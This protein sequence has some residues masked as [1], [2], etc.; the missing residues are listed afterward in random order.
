M[1]SVLA[2]FGLLADRAGAAS[3]LQPGDPVIAIDLD[4][5]LENSAYPGGETPANAVDQNSATK[6]LNQRGTETGLI[7]TPNFGSSTIQSFIITTAN[8]AADRDPTSYLLYGTNDAILSTDNS[9]GN[10]GEA[11]TQIAS[12]PVSLP[13][14]RFTPGTVA[15]FA[16]GLAF[17]SYKMLFPTLK[18]GSGSL[19]QIADLQFFTGAD[20]AGS[21][22]L[23]AGD[24]ALA[25]HDP[26][27]SQSSHPGGE[28]PPNSIDGNV[29]SKYLNFGE[30]NSG[31]IVT[32]TI[33]SSVVRSFQL[34]TANDAPARDPSSWAL[35]G[36]NDPITSTN[37]SFGNAEN[38][39]MIGS[40][41][42]AL[43]DDRFALGPQVQVPNET[44][45]TSYRFVFTG[46]KDAAAA[47]S[48]QIA[49]IQFFDVIPEP[50][51]AAL[52]ALAGILGLSASRRRRA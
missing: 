40:G 48:M 51:S 33:G 5:E 50:S 21:S 25:V 3:I 12:G 24:A 49:E 43:P 38:W 8:D 31:I 41:A 10:G 44:A 20:G 39:T 42:V 45:Y 14:T 17:S 36:T 6:Y 11:W 13:D 46:V 30:V 7:V 22:V 19:M 34:T 2:G 18:G 29:N 9:N 1:A 32:P 27:G 15:N 52:V 23:A 26:M 47:N 28:S 35:Y 16:N 4:T 37:N